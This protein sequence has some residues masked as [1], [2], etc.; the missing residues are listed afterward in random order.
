MRCQTARMLISDFI[1]G[2]LDAATASEV[3]AH[4]AHCPSCPPLA[5]ALQ[6]V[7]R[8]LRALPETVTA[9]DA[10][11]RALARVSPNFATTQGESPCPS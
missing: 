6:A 2:E 10:L 11:E 4:L 9:R 3:E 7:L 8:Q 1:D 5:V